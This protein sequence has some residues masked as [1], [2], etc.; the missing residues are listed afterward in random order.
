M[1]INYGRT[2]FDRVVIFRP[3][4]VYGPDMGWEHVLPQFVLRMKAQCA[5]HAAP[6]IDFPIQGS[7]AERRSFIFIDDFTD[8]LMKVAEQGQ[9]L[10][11]YHIGTE[12]EV[13]IADVAGLVGS[14]YGRDVKIVPGNLQKG[15]TLRRCP[16]IS[17]L[18][19]MGFAPKIP[20]RT[21]VPLLADWYDKNADLAPTDA[22]R[23]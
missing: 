12:E 11:I 21:G 23:S 22:N 2:H 13:A 9:H 6:S 8:G 5:G 14:F 3:H 4:N 20:L 15:G 10:G 1:A 18:K 7:G 16:D 17:K 19:R